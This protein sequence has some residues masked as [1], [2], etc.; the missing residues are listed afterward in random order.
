VRTAGTRV[1]HVCDHHP[2]QLVAAYDVAD[3]AAGR[4]HHILGL[5][6]GG[7]KISPPQV[8]EPAEQE[9]GG[10]KRQRKHRYQEAGQDAAGQSPLLAPAVWR[11]RMT[12]QN[13]QNGPG[14]NAEQEK[15]ASVNEDSHAAL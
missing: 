5:G 11:E 15:P 10:Y 6:T 2:A 12:H 14:Q 13:G 8:P 9:E 1:A 7:A 4:R 3:N